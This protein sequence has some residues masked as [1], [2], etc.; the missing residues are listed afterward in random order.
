MVCG[1]LQH[2]YKIF[3]GQRADA[4]TLLQRA[5]QTKAQDDRRVY[6]VA[7]A[8]DTRRD[9]GGND[10]ATQ[11]RTE[12][13]FDTQIGSRRKEKWTSTITG[14]VLARNAGFLAY[15]KI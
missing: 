14:Y 1:A 9:L 11:S 7:I 4:G 15:T 3:V 10:T 8:S 12:G 5:I 6:K 13:R 2:R